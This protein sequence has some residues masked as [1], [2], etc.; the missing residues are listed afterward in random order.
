MREP[1]GHASVPAQN[2]GTPPGPERG[3]PGRTTAGAR[4]AGRCNPPPTQPPSR[5]HPPSPANELALEGQRQRGKRCGRSPRGRMREPGQRLGSCASVG[6]TPDPDRWH[7]RVPPGTRPCL[8]P[9]RRPT[10]SGAARERPHHL[11]I[12]LGGSVSSGPVGVAV[13][14]AGVISNE[15]LRTLS[16]FPDLRVVGVADLDAGRATAVARE[17]GVPVAG[18][19]ATVLAVP[20]VELVVNLTVAGRPRA[21][22]DAGAAGRE[23]RVRREADRPGP[24]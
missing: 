2:W 3:P 9:S 5:P 22:R 8:L 17:H 16:S 7:R 21:G 24:R 12:R 11:R 4:S 14:G 1:H 18:D 6:H 15:Y 13:V 10:V 23:A 19:V 20:E